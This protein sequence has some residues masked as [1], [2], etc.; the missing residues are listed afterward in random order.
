MIRGVIFDLDGTLVTFNFD[1]HGSRSALLGELTRRGFDVSGLALSLPT[2]EI[3][4]EARRQVASGRVAADFDALK[5][6]LYTILDAFEAE[7]GRKSAPFP[8]TRATLEE[9]RRMSVRLA[10]VTNSGRAATLRL[11]G[12]Y[13]LADYFEFVLTRDDVE[14]LK[15]NPDGLARAVAR[16]SL[17]RSSLVCVGDSVLDIR[18]AKVA[19]LKIVS[20]STGNYPPQT[21]RAEGADEVI[22]SISDLPQILVN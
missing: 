12:R 2:Q 7:G 19:G 17:P 1:V 21:L 6:A 13:D 22:G 14:S 16:L 9:L 5:Q 15:P 4:D 10:L 11:L 18:A 20:V 3:V 8:D